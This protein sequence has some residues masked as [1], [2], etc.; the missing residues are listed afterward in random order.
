V[1]EPWIWNLYECCDSMRREKYGKKWPDMTKNLRIMLTNVFGALIKNIKR[2]KFY[3]EK[4]I[5]YTS[6]FI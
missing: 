5:E 4:S 2:I 3:I 6:I 1:F